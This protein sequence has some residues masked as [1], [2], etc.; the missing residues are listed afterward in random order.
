VLKGISGQKRNEIIA[1]WRKLKNEELH[2]TN[3]SPNIIR[4]IK[5]KRIR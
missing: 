2:S 1:G 3:F 5:S 4:M